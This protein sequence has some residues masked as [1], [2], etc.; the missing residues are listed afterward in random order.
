MYKII[1]IKKFCFVFLF[2]L[3]LTLSSFVNAKVIKIFF[4]GDLFSYKDLVGNL[5]LSEAIK[6]IS[7]GKY[8]CFL[9]QNKVQQKVHHKEIKDQ[10]LK[11][12]VNSDIAIFAFDGPE[13]DSGTVVEFMAAKFLD[14]PSVIY[15]TDFR[16]GS[17]EE[18]STKEQ[19]LSNKWN[20]M[21]SYYPRTKVIYLNGMVEYQ[22]VL[23]SSK[24]N[25]APSV[26]GQ[27]I[28][29]IAHQIIKAIEEVYYTPQIL[30]KKEYEIINKQFLTLMNIEK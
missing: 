19:E 21:V 29:Y 20:L 10:D 2:F 13:L 15:R 27:Y 11:G 30:N 1:N 8:E 16:G 17:G 9:A 23:K 7:N 12:L 4:A 22:N 3:S 6:K 25:S 18:V 14:K 5:Y 26:T 28:D 24:N